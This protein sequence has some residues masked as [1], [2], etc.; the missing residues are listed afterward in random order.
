MKG[1]QVSWR[2]VVRAVGPELARLTVAVVASL[3][4]GASLVSP[5]CAAQLAALGPRLIP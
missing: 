1:N 5:E 2:I 4:A 3:L